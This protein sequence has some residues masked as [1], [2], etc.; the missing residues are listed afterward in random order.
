MN[1]RCGWIS[2]TLWSDTSSPVSPKILHSPAV[3]KNSSWSSTGLLLVEDANLRRHTP[4]LTTLHRSVIE[5]LVMM[6]HDS[7]GKGSAMPF[8][9]QNFAGTADEYLDCCYVVHKF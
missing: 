2:K 4:G 5:K 1:S 6:T 9:S 7:L 3:P 8:H